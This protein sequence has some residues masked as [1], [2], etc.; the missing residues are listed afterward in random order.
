MHRVGAGVG[1]RGR[2]AQVQ[3]FEISYEHLNRQIGGLRIAGFIVD[4]GLS[5]VDPIASLRSE[6]TI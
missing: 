3:D 6:S 4:C 2:E 1:A 5:I